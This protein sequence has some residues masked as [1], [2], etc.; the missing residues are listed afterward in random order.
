MQ[1]DSQ[2][3]QGDVEDLPNKVYII[4]NNSHEEEL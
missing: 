2:Y 3:L 1:M 4:L